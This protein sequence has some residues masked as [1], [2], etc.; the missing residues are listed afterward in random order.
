MSSHM[1]VDLMRR[2][3]QF[4]AERARLEGAM[5]DAD[6][7]VGELAQGCLVTDLSGAALVVI[8]AGSGR[9]REDSEGSA[10]ERFDEWVVVDLASQHR[11]LLTRATGDRAGAGVVL[12]GLRAGVADEIVAEL[13]EH[14]GAEDL[15]NSGLAEEDLSIRMP[16]KMGLALPLQWVDRVHPV[17]GRDQRLDP[18]S[19]VGIDPD[20]HLD[21]VEVVHLKAE[22]LGSLGHHRV[23]PA[24]PR[25]SFGQPRPGQHLANR[26]LDLHVVVALGPVITGQQSHRVSKCLSSPRPRSASVAVRENYQ[27]PNDRVLTPRRCAADRGH[28]I[29]SAINSLGHRAGHALSSGLTSPGTKSAHLPTTRQPRVCRS[30]R[31]VT[32]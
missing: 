16:A 2:G 24:H 1:L 12:A 14:P 32:H 26:S 8:A 18:R 11:L 17:A 25:Y 15:S 7:T 10:A 28:D 3:G 6:E 21:L 23:E 4:V 27:L 31:L 22:R 9:G 29:P 19:A 30:G 13:C 20:L 5:E